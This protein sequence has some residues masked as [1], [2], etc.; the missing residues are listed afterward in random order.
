MMGMTKRRIAFLSFV[1]YGPLAMI[2]VLG[3]LAML[4]PYGFFQIVRAT[5][6]ND[7]GRMHILM[8]EAGLASIPV[9]MFMVVGLLIALGMRCSILLW[10]TRWQA[11]W[12]TLLGVGLCTFLVF[13]VAQPVLLTV[14]YWSAFRIA[15]N[16]CVGGVIGYYF[17][18]LLF[19]EMILLTAEMNW[20]HRVRTLAFFYARLLGIIEERIFLVKADRSTKVLVIRGCLADDEVARLY[21]GVMRL[22]NH[23]SVL[24]VHQG[25]YSTA[26]KTKQYE[27]FR[28]LSQAFRTVAMAKQERN[29]TDEVGLQIKLSSC[30]R[31]MQTDHSGILLAVTVAIIAILVVVSLWTLNLVK[32]LRVSNPEEYL[33]PYIEEY[34]KGVSPAQ[35]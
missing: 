4:L 35:K 5:L 3:S 13:L 34:H 27:Q 15:L 10:P 22:V 33:K 2:S 17:W 26:H 21:D 20:E 29:H 12:V 8:S 31:M 1:A 14:T 11:L 19:T 24:E 16:L 6:N 7:F 9:Y 18:L 28:R 32:P 23:L 30:E 25:R